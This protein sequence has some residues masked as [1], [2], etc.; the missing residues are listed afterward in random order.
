VKGWSFADLWSE[1]SRGGI[2]PLL[3]AL[4]Q[5]KTGAV[6]GLVGETADGDELELELL[7][8]PLAHRGE[9]RIRAL[10]VLAPMQPPYWLGEKA[11]VQLKLGTVRHLSGE[12]QAG[13]LLPAGAREKRGFV[14]YSGGR[15]PAANP[16]G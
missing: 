15:P 3:A 14:V 13:R 11:L 1:E 7:L 5:E 10:G 16:A 2:D 9:A 8:L 4:S 12:A 6:A